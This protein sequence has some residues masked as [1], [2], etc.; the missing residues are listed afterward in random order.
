MQPSSADGKAREV[1][2]QTA[3]E[4]SQTYLFPK[5]TTLE[6]RK[7]S[8]VEGKRKPGLFQS[9]A[10]SMTPCC[11]FNSLVERVVMVG[12]LLL[13]VCVCAT[14]PPAVVI[15]IEEELEVVSSGISAM[16][17]VDA[18]ACTVDGGDDEAKP[19]VPASGLCAFPGCGKVR[20]RGHNTNR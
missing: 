17:R 12:M 7:P 4:E 2:T 8:V 18:S 5:R 10:G 11:R 13:S 19:S 15:P 14:A 20:R 6:P 1:S 16:A 9:R 3:D